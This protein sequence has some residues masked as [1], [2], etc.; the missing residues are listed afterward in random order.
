VSGIVLDTS[1]VIAGI[2]PGEAE[3]ET[4]AISVITLGELRAGV[5]LARDPGSRAARQARLAAIASA[6]IP[7][8]VDEPVSDRTPR[9]RPQPGITDVRPRRPTC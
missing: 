8:S 4:A 6:F 5:L 2:D 9:S 7:L 3:D 1:V